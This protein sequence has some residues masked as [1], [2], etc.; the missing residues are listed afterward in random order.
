MLLAAE[1][2]EFKPVLVAPPV[3]DHR[4]HFPRNLQSRQQE[5]QAGYLAAI[6]FR[7]QQYA[8]SGFG[9][10]SAVPL[11]LL[12][13]IPQKMAHGH[14]KIGPVSWMPSSA[15]VDRGFWSR[16]RHEV[17][18]IFPGRLRLQL[19]RLEHHLNDLR[20]FVLPGFL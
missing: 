14:S 4:S 6:Q 9:K 1:R 16:G 18:T 20:S 19:L 5:A 3:A 8:D 2:K 12:V 17:K 13:F 7:S 11:Q 10:I 15:P